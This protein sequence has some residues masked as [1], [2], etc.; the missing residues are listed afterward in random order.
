MQLHARNRIK[1]SAQSHAQ[2]KCPTSSACDL[3]LLS[4][5]TGLYIHVAV[6]DRDLF[7][8]ELVVLI[9]ASPT[10]CAGMTVIH[11]HYQ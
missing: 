4:F 2:R 1:S 5:V 11:Y 10:L 8:F 3:P 9:E 6:P 7:C